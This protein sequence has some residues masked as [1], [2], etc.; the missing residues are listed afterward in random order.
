MHNYLKVIGFSHLHKQSEE[1]A[2]L[3]RIA[4]SP[5]ARYIIPIGE[6]GSLELV[7]QSFCAEPKY[8]IRAVGET[9]ENQHF[10][11]K[12]Y[13]PYAQSDMISSVD[14]CTITKAAGSDALNGCCDDYRLGMSLIFSISNFYEVLKYRALHGCEPKVRGVCL[15]GLCAE[16]KILLPV[17]K[18]QEQREESRMA[19]KQRILWMKAAKTGDADAI[20]SLTVDD[21][22][23]YNAVS[24][25]MANEDLYTV[26]DTYFIPNG[27]ECDQY[28]MMGEITEYR[29]LTNQE[30][31]EHIYALS[32]NTN[33]V[34]MTVYVNQAHLQGIPA[35]G[36]R[37]KCDLWLQGEVLL[38]NG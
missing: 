4:Q 22:N 1:K 2:L 36:M 35:V 11:V 3:Q 29:E 28:Q 37:I 7:E 8:G 14:E 17:E 25:R 16:A 15:S 18:T 31:G 13:Y 26:I 33:D 5:E 27:V 34:D 30:T 20:E 23:L 38:E 24:K 10:H 6:D 19:A 32:V 9:D 21:M 12:Y